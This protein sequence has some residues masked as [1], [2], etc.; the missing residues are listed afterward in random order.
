MAL[1]PAD[2][3]GQRTQKI[4]SARIKGTKRGMMRSEGRGGGEQQGKAQ[5]EMEMEHSSQSGMGPPWYWY[6]GTVSR[7]GLGAMI[8]FRCFWHYLQRHVL[9]LILSPSQPLHKPLHNLVN[10]LSPC[11]SVFQGQKRHHSVNFE[12]P[13]PRSPSGGPKL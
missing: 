3:R 9:V 7:A 4:Y 10:S 6:S 1:R 12:A 5:V 13:C 11:P 2:R 8:L